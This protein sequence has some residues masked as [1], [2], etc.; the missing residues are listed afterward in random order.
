MLS[1]QNEADGKIT[2]VAAFCADYFEPMSTS[3]ASAAPRAAAIRYFRL[4]LTSK[5]NADDKKAILSELP[6]F[7]GELDK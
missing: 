6:P 1:R 4:D 7:V 2:V 3:C 5:P